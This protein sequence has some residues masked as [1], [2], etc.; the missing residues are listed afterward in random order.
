M[1]AWWAVAMAM[2]TRWRPFDEARA[3]VRS[4]GLKSEKEWQAFSQS[5]KRP[6]DIPSHPGS[7]YADAGW[8]GWSDWL[9]EGGRHR[10]AG[11]RPF[12]EA[13]AFVRALEL[14]SLKAWRAWCA[15]GRRPTDI[16]IKFMLILAGRA[17]ATFWAK[18]GVLLMRLAPLC[19]RS[20]SK[21][22]GSGGPSASRE[23]GRPISRATLAELMPMR[24]GRAGAIGWATAGVVGALAGVLLERL[25]L[26]CAP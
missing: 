14:K 5:K 26:M 18:A 13:R 6:A 17:G 16:P 2:G 19:A 3:F 9:A 12:G 24:A 4:R 10:R 8:A 11:W 20:G 1:L 23:R 25:A 15:S 22:R 7:I 21:A